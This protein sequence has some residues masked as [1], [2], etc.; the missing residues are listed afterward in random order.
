MNKF[1]F[2]IFLISF[3]FITVFSSA[4]FT[5]FSCGKNVSNDKNAASEKNISGSKSL[6]DEK[7]SITH[8]T[9]YDSS[10]KYNYVVN[11]KYPQI[12][13]FT[14]KE[15]EDNFN[16]YIKEFVTDHVDTFKNEMI[17]WE[18]PG[19]DYQSAYEIADTIFYMTNDV[20]SIRLDGY[21]MF[22]GAAH[23]NTFF[24]SINYDLKNNKVIK[25]S[26]L[27][28]GSYMKVISDY[29]IKE[30]KKQIEEYEQNP[31]LRW[32]KE[33]AGPKKENYSVFNFTS[34][35]FVVTFPAYQVASYAEGPKEVVIP[36]SV[37]ADVMKKDGALGK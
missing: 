7:Y 34:D 3:V 18:N 16:K 4:G 25:L 24:Y 19:V 31:D 26:S 13:G 35:K 22:A 15:T 21:T 14:N 12:K 32:I 37:L 10:A 5:Y 6:T 36:L 28:D 23:P 8:E 2:N 17:S 30:L 1:S 29:C 20:I 27:F 33:G 9:M 11:V